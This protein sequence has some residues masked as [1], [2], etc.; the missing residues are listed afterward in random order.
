MLLLQ[1]QHAG[2]RIF[3]EV[4]QSALGDR[5]AIIL[6]PADRTRKDL[7]QPCFPAISPT[8]RLGN[9]SEWDIQVNCG[10]ALGSEPRI[11]GRFHHDIELP[12]GFQGLTEA[13]W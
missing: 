4:E 11:P 8:N 7:H 2:H 5:K 13:V 1:R 6:R 9:Y 10:S 12:F 3:N